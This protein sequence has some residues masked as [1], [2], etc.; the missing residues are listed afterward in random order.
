M[1]SFAVYVKTYAYILACTKDSL[2]CRAA[3][4]NANYLLRCLAVAYDIAYAET[5]LA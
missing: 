3:V 4:A 2:M 5:A 1:G